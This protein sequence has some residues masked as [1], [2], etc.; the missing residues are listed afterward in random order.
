MEAQRSAENRLVQAAK[1]AAVGEMAAGIAHELNNPLTSVT[2]FA[3]L[4]LDAIPKDSQTRNDLEI[5]MREANRARDVVRRLLDFA[6][7][8][9]STRARASLNEVIQD[10]VALS[11]HLIHTSGVELKLELEEDLP[12]VLADSNQMKQVLLNLVHNAL[13]A[14]PTGGEMIITTQSAVRAGRDWIMVR[15]CDTGVGIPRTELSRIFEPFYTTKGDQGGTG[16][17]LSVTYGIVTDHGG[18]IEVES[19]P[20]VGSKF[21]VWLPQ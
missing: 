12:W 21:T 1:L 4:A 19:E 16:L 7:Q 20:G 14:M 13:Q 15:V 10:V 9:E 6:R 2:G 3:E 5:V 8:S 11:R 18:Q 17:G